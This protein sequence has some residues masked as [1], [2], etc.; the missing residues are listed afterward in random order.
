MVACRL[1]TL[2][3]NGEKVLRNLRA[4]RNNEVPWKHDDR[5]CKISPIVPLFFEDESKMINTLRNMY[6]SEAQRDVSKHAFLNKQDVSLQHA[7]N[8]VFFLTIFLQ[9]PIAPKHQ[10]PAK[11]FIPVATTRPETNLGWCSGLCTSRGATKPVILLMVQKPGEPPNMCETLQI[12]GIFTYIYHINWWFAGFLVAINVVLPD[13]FGSP[14]M[15]G[16]WVEARISC[17]GCMFFGDSMGFF[18]WSAF[19][20]TIWHGM[21]G[22]CLRHWRVAKSKLFPEQT[23]LLRWVQKARK[24]PLEFGADE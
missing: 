15:I 9:E 22:T 20:T 6:F 5:N 4:S 11:E 21:F 13:W 24:L 10:Q 7:S 2:R 14:G 16:R 19:F 23:N 18:E 3:E 8:A 1:P 17:L 12:M